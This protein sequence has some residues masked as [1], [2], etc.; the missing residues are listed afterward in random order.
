MTPRFSP[1]LAHLLM[2]GL[3]RRALLH[4]DAQSD[5]PPAD[6]RP[7]SQK[8]AATAVA[9]AAAAAPVLRIPRPAVGTVA[10]R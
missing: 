8:Q 2:A 4:T 1:F 5:A 9:V 6:Q 3:A 10:R 7:S